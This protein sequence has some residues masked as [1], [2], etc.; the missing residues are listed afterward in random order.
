MNQEYIVVSD[1]TV[2]LDKE[3]LDRLNVRIIPMIYIL[4]GKECYYNPAEETID[5]KE[6][7]EKVN[8]G[9]PI[10]T[11]RIYFTCVFRRDSAETIIRL[12]SEHRR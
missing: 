12:M 3:I 5:Y 2:D 10:S 6:F 11:I 9:V 7:Y 1:A 8:A 4:D